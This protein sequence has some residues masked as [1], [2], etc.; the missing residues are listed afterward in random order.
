MYF[1][2]FKLLEILQ[3][4]LPAGITTIVGVV[5]SA[6]LPSIVKTVSSTIFEKTNRDNMEINEKIY[7]II[8]SQKRLQDTL[9]I[10]LEDNAK[11]KK[12]NLEMKEIITKIKS[13][14]E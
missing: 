13:G 12:Q 1:K 6:S 7:S 10:V 5:L 3:Q 14:D 2:K 11:L 4:W 8:E 9:S